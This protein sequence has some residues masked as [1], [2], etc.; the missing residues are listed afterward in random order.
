M[1]NR[2]HLRVKVLQVLYSYSLSENKSVKAFERNLLDSVDEVYEMYIWLLSLL[3]EVSDYTVIDAEERAN[4]FL[5]TQE[6]LNASIKLHENKFIKSL[7]ENPEF[8]SAVKKYKTSWSFD[9][10]V[11]RTIFNSLKA[12]DEYQQYLQQEDSSMRAE[13]DIIKHIFKKE[14][15]KSPAVEQI[16]EEKFIN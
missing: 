5:P 11:V 13:K 7:R 6:D 8:L 10:E 2:R 12:T 9:P 14:I 1:L 4:K 3:I 16:F 15:L